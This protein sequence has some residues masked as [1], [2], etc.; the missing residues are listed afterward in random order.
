MTFQWDPLKDR[1]NQQKHGAGY[2]RDGRKIYEKADRFSYQTR[3]NAVLRHYVRTQKAKEGS[4]ET[5]LAKARKRSSKGK[6]NT[7]KTAAK[8]KKPS[9]KRATIKCRMP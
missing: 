4:L 3:I 1:E 8:K 2:W 5:G 6:A 7:G 9:T